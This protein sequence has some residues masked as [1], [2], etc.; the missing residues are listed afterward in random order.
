L[1]KAFWRLEDRGR[2]EL[3]NLKNNCYMTFRAVEVVERTGEAT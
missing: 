1:E 3:E 2:N